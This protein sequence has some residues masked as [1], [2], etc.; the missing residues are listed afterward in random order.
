MKKGSKVELCERPIFDFETQGHKV[1]E[2][3]GHKF[4]QHQ[5]FTKYYEGDELLHSEP[6]PISPDEPTQW[7]FWGGQIMT[8]NEIIK[9]M[10]HI[11]P[12]AIEPTG[13]KAAMWQRLEN[14]KNNQET[15]T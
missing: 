9:A 5:E 8:G 1:F 12:E 11:G 10:K 15:R 6:M 13:G 3:K 2:H 14:I 7:A 4:I